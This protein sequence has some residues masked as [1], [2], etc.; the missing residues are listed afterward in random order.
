MDEPLGRRPKPIL[1]PMIVGDSIS[2]TLPQRER[3]ATW[4]TKCAMMHE[5][6]V[7]GETFYD[8]LDRRHFFNTVSPLQA[9]SVW[10]GKYTGTI[11]RH[12]VD[13]RLLHRQERP[14]G[15]VQIIVLTMVIG[16]LALQLTSAKW[17]TSVPQIDLPTFI[18]PTTKDLLFQVWPATFIEV[19]WPPPISFDDAKNRIKYLVVRFGGKELARNPPPNVPNTKMEISH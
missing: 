5:S 1:S 11:A 9:T 16:M 15:S 8:G 18:L 14:D 3:I 19:Q 2:L 6:I 4:L 12:I 13:Y 7:H 10:I 17:N